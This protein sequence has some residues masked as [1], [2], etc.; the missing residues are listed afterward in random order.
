M[1]KHVTSEKNMISNIILSKIYLTQQNYQ[2]HHG[3]NGNTPS[4]PSDEESDD[5]NSDDEI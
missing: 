3:S 1:K 5:E 4:D 2:H